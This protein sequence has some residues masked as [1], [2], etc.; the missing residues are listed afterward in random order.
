MTARA[1]LGA[2]ASVRRMAEVTVTADSRPLILVDVDDVLNLIEFSS[3][4]RRHLAHH[5]GWRRGKAW[6]GGREY[7]L[8]VNPAHGR[9]LRDLAGVAGAEL[10]WAT[11]LEDAAN[12]Y[13]APLLGLPRLPAVIPA[14][15]GEKAAHVVRWTAGRPWVWLDNDQGELAAAS[16]LARQAGQPHQCVPINPAIGLTARDAEL[17]RTWL[18]GE[19]PGGTPGFNDV[20]VP[21]GDASCPWSRSQGGLPE[22][23]R[24]AAR[25]AAPVTSADARGIGARD[26]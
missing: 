5:H 1:C 23:R 11:T 2:R 6:S 25:S 3:A 18:T 13:V 4:A 17:A 26:A 22:R 14:P 24:K 8:I 21:C 12:M 16:R 19:T 7:Q 10:A 15:V 9:L 20:N